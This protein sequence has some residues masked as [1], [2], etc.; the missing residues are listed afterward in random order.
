MPTELEVRSPSGTTRVVVRGERCTVGRDPSNDVALAGDAAVSRQHALLERLGGAWCV[1][2]LDSRNGVWVNG[3]R[4]WRER[5]LE[6][7]DEV[8]IGN[9]VFAIV[10]GEAG[11]RRLDATAAADRPPRLTEGER[12]V[13]RA[14]CRPL[15][16]AEPF[17]EPASVRQ[18]AGELWVSEAAVKQH[19]IR[20]YAKFAVPGGEGRRARL[21]NEAM[22]RGAVA[23]PELI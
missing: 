6:R 2:D 15:L 23:L 13:L 12:R 10:P 8:R 1:R 5:R 20:L 3:E 7:G 17:T 14:L 19:L 22:R 16:R 11:A 9:S 21:A 4:I 18:I